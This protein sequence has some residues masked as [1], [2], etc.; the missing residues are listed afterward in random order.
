MWMQYNQCADKRIVDVRKTIAAAAIA[1][2][3]GSSI[4]CVLG[5]IRAISHRHHLKH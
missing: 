2:V 5:R 1:A 4:L 3:V